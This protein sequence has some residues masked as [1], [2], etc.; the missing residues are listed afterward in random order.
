[1][2]AT[3]EGSVDT[4][5]LGNFIEVPVTSDEQIEG[6]GQLRESS[7]GRSVDERLIVHLQNAVTS[8]PV[9]PD[10]MPLPDTD[11]LFAP[12]NV[13]RNIIVYDDLDSVAYLGGIQPSH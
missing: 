6:Q 3:F 10:V 7:A 13:C 9:D 2:N 5:H 11:W 1:M 12:L 4:R 8:G